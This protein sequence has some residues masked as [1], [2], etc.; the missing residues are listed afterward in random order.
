MS[1]ST[2]A[3]QEARD[4]V[5][6][7]WNA[8]PGSRIEQQRLLLPLGCMYTPLKQVK[9]VQQNQIIPQPGQPGYPAP[10]GAKLVAY[11]PVRCRGIPVGGEESDPSDLRRDSEPV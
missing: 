5:R 9:Q 6:M 4:G 1:D 7:T 8:F 10:S 2:I 11:E 3:D